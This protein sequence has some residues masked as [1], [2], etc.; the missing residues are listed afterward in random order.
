MNHPQITR[1]W[2]VLCWN[3]RGI[4]SQM[5]WDAVKDKIRES[6][7]DIIFLQETKRETFDKQYLRNFYPPNFDAFEF[8]PSV[9]AS[10][11]IITIWNRAQF[12]GSLAYNNSFSLFVEL[13]SNHNDDFWLLTNVYGP[14]TAEGKRNFLNWI[15]NISMPDEIDWLVVG[16]FNLIRGPENRNRPGGDI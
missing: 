14:C 5:K 3:V 12:S 8:V 2:K 7:C 16:D 4:N 6:Q 11:G 1:K 15:Q 9:G 13:R 10:G